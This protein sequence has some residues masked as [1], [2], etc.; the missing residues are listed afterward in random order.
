MLSEDKE[1]ERELEHGRKEVDE[2][3]GK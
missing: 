3:K 1:Q 2:M